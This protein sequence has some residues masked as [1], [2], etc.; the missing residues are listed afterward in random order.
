M[1]ITQTVTAL[2]L[3]T[4]SAF[5][6]LGANTVTFDNQSGKPALVKVVGPTSTSISVA[7]GKRETLDVSAGHY[8]IKVRYGAPNSYSYSKGDEFDVKETTTTSSETTITL[9]LVKDGN[10]GTRRITEKDF[11]SEKQNISLPAHSRTWNDAKVAKLVLTVDAGDI[12]D[13]PKFTQHTPNEIVEAGEKTIKKGVQELV[14]GL[15]AYSNESGHLFQFK[16]DT[17]SN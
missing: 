10:Y 13:D 3:A 9:H 12:I 8:F 7:N 14:D 1:K 17:H 11:D 16:A 2:I 6:A 5:S 4:L 15:D